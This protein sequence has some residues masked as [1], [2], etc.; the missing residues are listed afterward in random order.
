[1]DAY[2][3]DPDRTRIDYYRRLWNEGDISSR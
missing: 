2:G 3:A 1:L